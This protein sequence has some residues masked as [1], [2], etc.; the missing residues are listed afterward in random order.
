MADI[1]AARAEIQ[2]AVG[3]LVNRFGHESDVFARLTAAL[4]ALNEPDPTPT[5]EETVAVSEPIPLEETATAEP[6]ETEPEA[7][8]P[9]EIVEPAPAPKKQSRRRRR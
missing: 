1:D 5:I 7:T 2:K 6:E 3:L 9:E 8:V 4:S